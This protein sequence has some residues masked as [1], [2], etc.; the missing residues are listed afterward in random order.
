MGPS[1]EDVRHIPSRENLWEVHPQPSQ[2]DDGEDDDTLGGA[3]GDGEGDACTRRYDAR[4]HV[5][6]VA[7]L[8]HPSDRKSPYEHSDDFQRHDVSELVEPSEEKSGGL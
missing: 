8:P 4:R 6:V 2:D 5:V 1:C 7:V 3:H